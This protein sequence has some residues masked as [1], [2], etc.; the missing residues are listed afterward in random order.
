MQK[1]TVSD[2]IRYTEREKIKD[3][4]CLDFIKIWSEVVLQNMELNIYFLG[5]DISYTNRNE[6]T[7]KIRL[8]RRFSKIIG[9]EWESQSFNK[10]ISTTYMTAK[11]AD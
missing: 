10:Y 1:G 9:N 6:K 7:G 11:N 5:Y 3:Q 2:D 4:G 8:I